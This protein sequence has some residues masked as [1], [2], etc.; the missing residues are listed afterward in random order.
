MMK[1]RPLARFASLVALG[2][3]LLMGGCQPDWEALAS[4]A[5]QGDV[6]AQYKYAYELI[7]RREKGEIYRKLALEWFLVAAK[8]GYAPAQVGAATCYH[9]ALA[10][11]KDVEKA[12]YWYQQAARQGNIGAY[13]GMLS[14][15]LETGEL[16]GAAPWV[17]KLALAGDINLQMQYARMLSEGVGVPMD[18]REA[19][20]FWRYAA[21]AGNDEACLIM[22]M[23]YAEGWGVPI[24]PRLA[25]GWWQLAADAGN[26]AAKR[27][28]KQSL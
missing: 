20:N 8:A 25:R 1:T 4:G 24:E 16:E 10:G 15:E 7:Q 12:R 22:G 17:R 14:L 28:I 5:Q 13:K 21:M 26:K 23:C 6:V 11:P 19:V 27:L 18:E 9:L 3:C 2:G